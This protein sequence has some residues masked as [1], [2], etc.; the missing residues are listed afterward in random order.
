MSPYDFQ[1]G[2]TNRRIQTPST[3]LVVGVP[4][5]AYRT[6]SPYDFQRT[7]WVVPRLCEGSPLKEEGI[8]TLPRVA[9]NDI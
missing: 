2:D 9:R 1:I 6:L 3:I 4:I 7:F 8:A 5:S